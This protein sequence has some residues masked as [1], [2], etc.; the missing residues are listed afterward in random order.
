MQQNLYSI[1][2]NK[3]KLEVI[4]P[5][6][7]PD[8]TVESTLYALWHKAASNPCSS[9]IALQYPLEELSTS[10]QAILQNLVAERCKGKPLMQITGRAHFMGI[11]LEFAPEI[12]I[13]RPE[14]EILGTNALNIL[15]SIQNPVLI[16]VGC[17][18]GNL[19]CGIAHA[20]PTV[21]IYATDILQSCVDLCKRNAKRIGIEKQVTTSYGNLFSSLEKCCLEESVDVVISNPPYIA[22]SRLKGDRAYLVAYEPIEALDGGPFGFG[23]H[24]RLIKDSLRFLKPGG[25]LLF[26]FG[27]GQDKQ[28]GNLIHRAGGYDNVAFFND[29][30]GTARVVIARKAL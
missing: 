28:V 30:N 22:S 16:D 27:T 23:I 24:Q 19:S 9:K 18:S 7:Q 11:E 17:G 26:E 25:H 6:D 5:S 21:T 12:F 4:L 8:E 1:L 14:T 20:L 29:Q 3:I 10:Q 2:M 15:K 13:V